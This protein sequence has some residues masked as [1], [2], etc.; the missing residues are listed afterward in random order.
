MSWLY[1][2]ILLLVMTIWAPIGEGS[3]NEGDI[4]ASTPFEGHINFEVRDLLDD[5]KVPQ[6]IRLTS[7]S[8]RVMVNSNYR[9]RVVGGLEASGLL[10]R[11]DQNDFV[12]MNSNEDA[13]IIS[14]QEVD[15]FGEMIRRL[16][17]GGSTGSGWGGSMQ[18]GETSAI[19]GYET[20]RVRLYQQGSANFMDIWLTDQI[21]VNWGSVEEAWRRSLSSMVQLDMPLEMVM[22]SGRFPLQM[23]WYEAGQPVMHME[24]LS[25][26]N[27]RVSRSQVEIPENL[28][29]IGYGDLM[30]RMMLNRR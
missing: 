7:N 21:E 30:M 27:S 6:R 3:Q 26:E 28:K 25:V 14:S 5:E 9:Y 20:E 15:S 1:T 2:S 24:T 13:F 22:E 18:T 23:T 19:R 8:E 12:F 4:V 11:N 10:V 16:R 17:G 29:L